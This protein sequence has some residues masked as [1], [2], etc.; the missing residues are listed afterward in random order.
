M[1]YFHY[2]HVLQWS[3]VAI[4]ARVAVNMSLYFTTREVAARSASYKWKVPC[5][6]TGLGGYEANKFCC[7]Q[8]PILCRG[9]WGWNDAGRNY[10]VNRGSFWMVRLQNQWDRN[11][12]AWAGHL[13]L[14]ASV[15][16]HQAATIQFVSLSSIPHVSTD[17]FTPAVAD[18]GLSTVNF[19]GSLTGQQMN[20]GH[21]SQIPAVIMVILA[22][23]TYTWSI[24]H[25]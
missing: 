1:E 17:G 24:M 8:W 3:K 19:S 16:L 25:F 12:V 22:T 5:N 7:W 10:L 4:H 6:V 2:F 20:V 13:Q 21:M 15:R 14:E 18:S 23:N 9:S 11:K